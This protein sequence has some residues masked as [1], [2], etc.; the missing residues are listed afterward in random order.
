ME[1]FHLP[2]REIRK[3]FTKSEIVLMGWRSQ[4]Q[5]FNFKK[6]MAKDDAKSDTSGK[7]RKEYADAYGPEGMPDKYFNE[8]GDFD[9]S[10]VTGEEARA[11]LEG[12]LGISFP[13]GLSK[14]RDDSPTSQTIR[15]AYGVR[16]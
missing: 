14:M 16:R 11:Y 12:K 5:S 10:K 13:P 1:T 2:L 6:R 8:E 4:E 9:L 7:K 15:D 3:R